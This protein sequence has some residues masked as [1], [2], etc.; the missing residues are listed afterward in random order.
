M[1]RPES[2]RKSANE[3]V[4]LF[5]YPYYLPTYGVSILTITL[6]SINAI[7]KSAKKV[8]GSLL[9]TNYDKTDVR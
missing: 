5:T 4:P 6:A 7:A 1:H 8:L 3:L 9:P 2:S